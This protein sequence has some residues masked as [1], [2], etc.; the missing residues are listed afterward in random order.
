MPMYNPSHPSLT[1]R[2]DCLEPLGLNVTE[3]AKEL[4]V[5]RQAL[6]NLANSKASISPEM[7]C[8]WAKLAA[9]CPQCGC[10]CKWPMTSPKCG[11]RKS[12]SSLLH[13]AP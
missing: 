8:A 4:G 3:G 1:V 5:A 9:I 11:G 10:S 12:A 6:N 2:H 13:A 7:P